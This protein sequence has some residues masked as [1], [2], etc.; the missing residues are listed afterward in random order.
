M[1]QLWKGFPSTLFSVCVLLVLNHG[2]QTRISRDLEKQILPQSLNMDGSTFCRD[3]KD[4]LQK[5]C[6]SSE[7]HGNQSIYIGF[8]VSFENCGNLLYQ[9]LH[10]LVLIAWIL[11]FL[12][13]FLVALLIAVFSHVLV[14]KFRRGME[15][16]GQS[17]CTKD[18][19][20]WDKLFLRGLCSFYNLFMKLVLILSI[21]QAKQLSLGMI[22]WNLFLSLT[23]AEAPL[24][25][26]FWMDFG[27]FAS[28]C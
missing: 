20:L 3:W 11:T 28:C 5:G 6:A 1:V 18:L 17:D 27:P 21:I 16:Y 8:L 12:H 7:Q 2:L 19:N 23:I 4:C 25:G 26:W 9:D 24:S 22:P 14:P 10:E 15:L 13:P